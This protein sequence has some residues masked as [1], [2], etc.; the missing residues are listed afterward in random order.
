MPNE[1]R[2]VGENR[3]FQEA[4]SVPEGMRRFSVLFAILLALVAAGCLGDGSAKSGE[5]ANQASTIGAGSE[6]P[7]ITVV[8]SVSAG[9]FKNTGRAV[10]HLSC[11]PPP[12][13]ASGAAVVCQQ[14]TG[15]LDRYFPESSLGLYGPVAS[16]VVMGTVNGKRVSRFY[17]G[18]S[19]FRSWMRLLG[20][21]S[22]G[23]L[24]KHGCSACLGQRPPSTTQTAGA[25]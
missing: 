21:D 16:M 13:D 18:D 6:S 9:G 24:V 7:K 11:P 10:Y 20:R 17:E 15:D 25:S 3:N 2:A 12:S 23:R 22:S 8:V 14:L 4:L 1:E 5:A 19:T